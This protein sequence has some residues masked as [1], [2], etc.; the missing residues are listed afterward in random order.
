MFFTAKGFSASCFVDAL[1]Q[2]FTFSH[3]SMELEEGGSRLISDSLRFPARVGACLLLQAPAV[4]VGLAVAI[5]RCMSKLVPR[6]F[7]VFMS[8][9][10]QC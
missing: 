9:W 8:F 3:G 10:S 4:F 1:F 5:A 6:A 7:A 2:W